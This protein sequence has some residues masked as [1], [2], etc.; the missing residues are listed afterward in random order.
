MGR[1]LS[2]V[3]RRAIAAVSVFVLA[4]GAAMGKLI[5]DPEGVGVVGWDPS[6]IA[7][8][9]ETFTTDD[10]GKYAYLVTQKGS[11]DPV[12]YDPCKVI[13]VQL[14]ERTGPPDARAQVSSALDEVTE[15]TGLSFNLVGTS[16]DEVEPTWQPN[17]EDDRPEPVL[18][19]WTDPT[20]IPELSGSVAGL[21][22]SAWVER[23]G[24]RRYV[25]GRVLLDGPQLNELGAEATRAV[26]LHELAHLVGLAHVGSRD[27]LM[28]PSGRLVDWGSGDLAGLKA[29]G[30]SCS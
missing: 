5:L 25:T 11:R 8:E 30:G 23:D 19:A 28:A 20:Q 4:L 26:I 6:S 15:R 12:R 27:E 21:G 16:A 13:E 3:R 14:N 2:R 17:V 22:G 7:S 1:S 9:A 18:I 24:V 10:G 29:V